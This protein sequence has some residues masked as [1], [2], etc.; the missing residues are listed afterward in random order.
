MEA[1]RES[2]G[3]TGRRARAKG[4]AWPLERATRAG[5]VRVRVR[6]ALGKRRRGRARD[7]MGRGGYRLAV[8]RRRLA[9]RE[10]RPAKNSERRFRPA[11]TRKT[12]V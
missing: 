4:R 2:G 5:G 1:T 8:S 10:R 9:N 7:R 12:T 3:G 6:A 11:V